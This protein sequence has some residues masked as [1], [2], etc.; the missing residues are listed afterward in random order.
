MNSAEETMIPMI[1]TFS[2]IR[3]LPLVATPAEA[4]AA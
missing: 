4:G 2:M 3:S 1:A